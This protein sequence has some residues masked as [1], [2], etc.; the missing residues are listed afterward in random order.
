[1]LNVPYDYL[2]LMHY[3]AVTFS[4]D[5]ENKEYSMVPKD[6]SFP[7]DKLGQ[8]RGF[9]VIDLEQV[10]RFYNCPP[11]DSTP[12]LVDIT[13]EPTS[14]VDREDPFRPVPQ[15]RQARHELDVH[16]NDIQVTALEGQPVETLTSALQRFHPLETPATMLSFAQT[17]IQLNSGVCSTN[18]VPDA[19]LSF[20][21]F[22]YLFKGEQT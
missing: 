6:G 1:M 15:F 3:S 20:L 19:V 2:S 14:H 5:P 21:G 9:S 4:K 18:F 7:A 22:F 10:M 17:S 12:P 11:K 16:D 13:A 8:R